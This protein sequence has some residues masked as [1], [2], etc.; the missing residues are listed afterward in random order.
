MRARGEWHGMCNGGEGG[1]VMG[2]G[3]RGPASSR[4]YFN[5]CTYV[6]KRPC[7]PSHCAAFVSWR[8]QA[9]RV[10]SRGPDGRL[11]G[12]SSAECSA[13][14]A[15]A[16]AENRS[17]SRRACSADA[18]GQARRPWGTPA[19]SFFALALSATCNTAIGAHLPMTAAVPLHRQACARQATRRASRPHGI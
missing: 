19:M 12:L 7:A 15:P 17:S 18:K 4:R 10:S 5:Q 13:F 16:A 2:A 6:S 11:D 8:Y 3:Q 14:V 9:Y 1:N